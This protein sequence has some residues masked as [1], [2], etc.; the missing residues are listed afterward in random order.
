MARQPSPNS[1]FF[2]EL[3]FE[4]DER[5]LACMDFATG[6]FPEIAIRACFDALGDQHLSARVAQYARSDMKMLHRGAW[7]SRACRGIA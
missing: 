1:N 6:E 7:A 5:G 2:E 3:T 4:C